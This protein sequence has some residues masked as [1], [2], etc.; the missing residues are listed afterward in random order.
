MTREQAVLVLEAVKET[1]IDVDRLLWS[2][3]RGQPAVDEVTARRIE[4]LVQQSYIRTG[5]TK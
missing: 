2:V 3:Q 1:G 4:K 5:Y